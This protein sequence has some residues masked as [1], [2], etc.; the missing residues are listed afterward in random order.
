MKLKQTDFPLAAPAA[1]L[2]TALC[3]ILLT[4]R[5]PFSAAAAFFTAPFGSIYYFGSWLNTASFLIIAGTGAAFAVQSGNMNLGGEGA[6]C[7][8]SS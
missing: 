5:H 4:S 7:R 2:L 3:I 6:D 1:G 8:K